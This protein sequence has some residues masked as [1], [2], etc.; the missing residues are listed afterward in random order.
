MNVQFLR[1]AL[2]VMKIDYGQPGQLI[3]N[4]SEHTNSAT[5]ER[6]VNAEVVRIPKVVLAPLSAMRK[7]FFDLSYMK[8]NN[9]FTYGGDF[10]V[11]STIVFIDY[12]Y[13]AAIENEMLLDGLRYQ[14][15]KVEHVAK[16]FTI[17]T[18]KAQKGQAVY[19][20]INAEATSTLQVQGGVT[21]D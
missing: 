1:D 15:A 21:N 7:F 4:I 9:N 17:L 6:T 13:L 3:K 5:G 19:N 20:I 12:H 8:A 10:D 14:I 2:Y 16:V 11:D 18:M